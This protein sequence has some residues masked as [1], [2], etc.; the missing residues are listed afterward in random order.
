MD[1]VTV[2]ANTSF[3]SQS[4][5]SVTRKQRLT[6]S[7]Q[8]A[9]EFVTMKLVRYDDAPIKK[10]NEAVVAGQVEPSASLPVATALTTTS[11]PKQRGGRS[12]KAGR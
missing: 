11:L 3:V 2:I 5:G 10:P 9:H 7:K 12:K 1:Q 8:L 4:V 6:L